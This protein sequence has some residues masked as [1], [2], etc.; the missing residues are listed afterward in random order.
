MGQSSR[1]AGYSV[2]RLIGITCAVFG[3]VSTARPVRADLEVNVTRVGFPTLPPQGDVVRTGQWAPVI[4]DVALIAQDRFDGVVRV[5]QFDVDGDEC[6]DSHDLHLRNETEGVRLYLYLLPNQSQNQGRFIVEVFDE[7]GEAVEVV[8]QGELTFQAEPAQ[9]PTVL[10]DDSVLIMSMSRGAMG[11]IQDLVGPDQENL[12]RRQISIGHMSPGDLPE[13]WIGLEAV[14][15]IVWDDADPD[16][17]TERQRTALIEWVRQGGTLLLAASRTAASLRLSRISTDALPLELG[18]VSP[19]DNL[20][21]VRRALL[22]APGDDAGWWEEPFP[23][24]V[25]IAHGTLRDGAKRVPD[26]KGNTSNVVTRRRLGRGEVIFCA[27]TLA[28]LFSAPGSAIEFFQE[29]FHLSVLDSEMEQAPTP[30]RLFPHVLSGIAFSEWSSIYIVLAGVFSI[31]YVLIATLGTWAL[32][33]ARGWRQHSWSAFAVVALAASVLS[34]FAVNA[35]RGFGGETLHQISVVDADAGDPIGFATIFLGVKTGSDRE[36]DLWLPSDRLGAD[37]PEETDCFLRPVPVG[38]DFDSATDR[39]VDPKS[40]RLA[41]GSAVID[42]VRI[43]ATLKRFE[44]RWKG[45]L[46]GSVKSDVGV[47]GTT[48][49]EGSYL[50]NNLGVDLEDCYLLQPSLALGRRGEPRNTSIYAF[51]IGDIH[52]GEEIDLRNK[53]YVIDGEEKVSDSKSSAKLSERQKDWSSPF[54]NLLSRVGSGSIMGGT[55]ALGQEKNALLLASTAG[56]YQAE[57]SATQYFVSALTPSRDRLRQLDL[58]DR[59]AQD[60]LVLIGFAKDPGP[61]R[62]FRRTGERPFRILEPDRR[63]SWTMYRIRIPARWVSASDEDED[64]EV[65]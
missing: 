9:A 65:R 46:G 2:T 16:D 62:L 23:T 51:F 12:Y 47:R 41:P 59:L 8:S 21:E 49:Q 55:R 6:F 30:Y 39:F 26:T 4:V 20:P 31:A 61:V 28:D 15:Y 1:R 22:G 50:I 42:N 37:E 33:G 57:V 3:M 53:C 17:L 36:L 58:R 13:L 27:I 35:I 44:G 56:D 40:Y 48:I 63:K 34:V 29:M 32:L 38:N 14:D 25:L 19:V 43:R 54:R 5:G 11:R 52:D 18:D 10:D 64:E 24:P 45:P 60:S 7:A